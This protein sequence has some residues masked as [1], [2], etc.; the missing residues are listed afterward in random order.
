[1]M[2]PEMIDS[3]YKSVAKLEKHVGMRAKMFRRMDPAL[4]TELVVAKS[5]DGLLTEHGTFSWELSFWEDNLMVEVKLDGKSSDWVLA[6]L[7]NGN[8]S[9]VSFSNDP[10]KSEKFNSVSLGTVFASLW[11]RPAK[12]TLH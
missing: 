3:I 4:D 6:E 2:F 12:P 8:Y 11:Q 9:P 10:P 1:M 7:K 5:S